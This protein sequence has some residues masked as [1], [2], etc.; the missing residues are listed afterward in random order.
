[1]ARTY[2]AAPYTA[3]EALERRHA[4]RDHHSREARV[5][6]KKGGRGRYNWGP[7]VLV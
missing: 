2:R 5:M 6:T 7:L 1:M 3:K 4:G